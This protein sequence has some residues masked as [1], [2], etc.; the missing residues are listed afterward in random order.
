MKAEA[1]GYLEISSF[2]CLAWCFDSIAA[3][4][5]EPYTQRRQVL[6]VAVLRAGSSQ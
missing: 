1:Q 2:E 4:F 6:A 3:R 5:R